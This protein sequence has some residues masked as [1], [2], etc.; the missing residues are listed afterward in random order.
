M[1]FVKN[2]LW[3][4]DQALGLHSNPDVLHSAQHMVS[5]Q[6]DICWVNV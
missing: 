1:V 5:S 6:Y 4:R 3:G 2:I